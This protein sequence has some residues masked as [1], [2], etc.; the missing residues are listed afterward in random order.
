MNH[1][2]SLKPQGCPKFVMSPVEKFT[3]DTQKHAC[4]NEHPVCFATYDAYGVLDLG[5]SK[6]VI[7]SNH[8]ASL[9]R[10][11]DE[12]S[13]A[14]LSR[15]SCQITFKFGNQGTL[16]SQQALIVP[17]G[18]LRL[19]VAI[20][21]GDTPFLISNTFMRAIRAQIDCFAH[22]LTSPQLKHDVQLELT[23]RGLFL[24]NLNDIIKAAADNTC[25]ESPPTKLVRETFLTASEG[26]D[27]E[28]L[29]KSQCQQNP[30]KP[31]SSK[32][33]ADTEKAVGIVDKPVQPVPPS[34]DVNAESA[35]NIDHHSENLV[36]DPAFE[37]Q[38][39]QVQPCH[40]LI[41]QSAEESPG[42]DASGVD[43]SQRSDPCGSVKGEDR[44]RTEACG[45]N[46]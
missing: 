3:K 18:Q 13:R 27:D 8:V 40:G 23:P 16:T 43:R 31:M 26:Q 11:L 1:D 17:I 46:L 12:D 14:K 15:C 5:A 30:S 35:E 24:V 22:R 39:D 38:S 21:E 34:G 45:G 20:V 36:Q 41:D 29:S 2:T 32:K 4:Q 33:S 37:V 7:G 10:S 44:I 25:A 9:I 42:R 19:K 28:K 6:T